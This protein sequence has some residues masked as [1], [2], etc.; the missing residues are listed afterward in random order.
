MLAL[1]KLRN[2]NQGASLVE[3][4]LLFPAFAFLFFGALEVSFMMWQIQQGEIAVKRALRVATTRSVL[5]D[6]AYPDC[7]PANSTAV[8]GT[9]CSDLPDDTGEWGNCLINDISN[10]GSPASPCGTDV[11]RVAQEIMA[12]YPKAAQGDVRFIF[13]GS[14][15][16]FEGLGKP[17]PIITVQFENVPFSTIMLGVF[18][19]FTMATQS[20]SA[21]AEDLT[22]GPG[23]GT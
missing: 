18:G 5:E 21:P 4:A 7:G 16:G 10:P 22:N 23:P 2:N 9:L 6:G 13:S 12:F 15:L 19:N 3:F 11:A 8:L 17:V 14:G 20:A 1:R